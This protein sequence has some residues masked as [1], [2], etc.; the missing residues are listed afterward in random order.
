MGSY[1]EL[2]SEMH[3][4]G[5]F[6]P[7]DSFGI[8]TRNSDWFLMERFHRGVLQLIVGDM[9]AQATLDVQLRQA[10]SA[11]GAGAKAVTGKAITQMTQAGGD[12]NEYRVIELQTEQMDVTNNYNYIRVQVVIAGAAVEYAFVF[13]AYDPRYA[14]V[15]TTNYGEVVN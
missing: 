15:P 1:T 10:T 12:G 8:S 7:A 3:E 6:E 5:L 14:P 2:F 11:A 13:N 4:P 9:Q